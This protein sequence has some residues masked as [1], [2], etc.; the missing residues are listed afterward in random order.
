MVYVIDEGSVFDAPLDKIWKYLSSDQHRHPSVKML[1]REVTGNSVVL[2]SERNIGGKLAKAK[3]R[4]TLYPP[5][6]MVQEHLEG[7]MT[8]SKA[9]S[10]YIPKGDRTGIT[11]VGDFVIEGLDE[12]ATKEALLAQFQV[13]FDED[14]ANLKKMS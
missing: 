3:V 10:Y 8:G 13:T 9:F 5:F 1:S 14:N 6:G 2:T 12:K 7:P 4:N 11:I